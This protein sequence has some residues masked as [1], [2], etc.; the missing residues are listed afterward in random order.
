M[1]QTALQQLIERLYE[2]FEHDKAIYEKL[3]QKENFDIRQL[4]KAKGKWHSSRDA[5]KTACEFLEIEK[6]DI[7][8]A[9]RAGDEAEY[10]YLVKGKPFIKITEEQYYTKTFK[11]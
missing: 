4:E 5:W 10:Q 2:R 6:Q 8:E 9:Y 3:Q 7:I 11:K 1:K